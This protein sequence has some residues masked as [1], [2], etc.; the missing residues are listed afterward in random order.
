VTR[1]ASTAASL[2]SYFDQ[3]GVTATVTDR[4]DVPAEHDRFTAVVIF[5]DEF[6]A[7]RATLGVRALARQLSR[8]WLVVVT[9]HTGRFSALVATLDPQPPERL[10]VLPRP[11]WGWALLDRVLQPLPPNANM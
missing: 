1:N 10:L 3:S 5:P 4:I 8:A 2:R 6:P 11:A 7:H 9:R